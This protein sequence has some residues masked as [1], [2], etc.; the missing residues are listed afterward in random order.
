MV[1]IEWTVFGPLLDLLAGPAKPVGISAEDIHNYARIHQDH[2]S[3][4]VKR[5]KSFVLP[6]TFP[7][8]SIMLRTLRPRLDF[9]D[10]ISM[11][12]FLCST[13][14]SRGRKVLNMML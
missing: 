3:P 10:L 8:A 13:K 5:S 7:P 12:P 14:S 1:V 11:S 2:S 9:A 6:L 4:R